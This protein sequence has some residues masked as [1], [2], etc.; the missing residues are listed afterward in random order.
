[1]SWTC[2][3]KTGE[4]KVSSMSVPPRPFCSVAYCW[5]FQ[6]AKFSRWIQVSQVEVK[7]Q[8]AV[9]LSLI[10]RAAAK[11]SLQVFGGLAGSRPALVRMS[12]LK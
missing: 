8:G 11:T 5:L 9:P 4:L 7:P 2:L 1:M 3:T 10:L 6:A 12:L